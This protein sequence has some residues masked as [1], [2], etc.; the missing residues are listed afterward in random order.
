MSLY[1]RGHFPE[2]LRNFGNLQKCRL[3]GSFFRSLLTKFVASVVEPIPTNFR[4]NTEESV[5]LAGLYTCIL[6]NYSSKLQRPVASIDRQLLISNT[7][8]PPIKPLRHPHLTY[9]KP[10]LLQRIKY[11]TVETPLKVNSLCRSR[12]SALYFSNLNPDNVNHL[13]P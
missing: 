12:F 3:L 4:R 2:D 9:S 13:G 1:F 10:F 5:G 7:V 6:L 8:I 11:N